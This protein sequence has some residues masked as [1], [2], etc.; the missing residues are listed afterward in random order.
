MHLEIRTKLPD[1]IKSGWGRESA[2]F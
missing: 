2:D 1:G